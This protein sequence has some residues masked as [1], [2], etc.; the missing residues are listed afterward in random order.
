MRWGPIAQIA[1][2]VAAS[3]GAYSFVRAAQA[4]HRRAACGSLCQLRP[5]YAGD[6][7]TV[8]DFELPDLSGRPVKISS[9]VG[10]GPVVLN[11]WTK[12]CKP[13]LQELPSLAEL[14]RLVASDGVRVVT[15]CTDSGPEAVAEELATALGGREPPFAVLFD[16]DYEVVSELFGTTLYP[17]TWLIDSQGIIR[18]RIDGAR[19]WT[20]SIALEVIEMIG[21][22]LGCPMEFSRGVPTGPHEGLCGDLSL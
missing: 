17:E 16:P 5:A 8:P 11:F 22:P 4:D 15:V 13:C 7:R 1:F 6:N 21:R 10:E 12:S 19:D 20:S 18:A 2:I 14:A 9:L 3:V